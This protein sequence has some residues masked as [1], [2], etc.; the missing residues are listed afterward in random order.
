M[1]VH[2]G[3]TD[4]NTPLFINFPTTSCLLQGKLSASEASILHFKHTPTPLA[5]VEQLAS[6]GSGHVQ[7]QQTCAK[8]RGPSTKESLNCRV[9]PITASEVLPDFLKYI[10]HQVKGQ[11]GR[12]QS[13]HVFTSACTHPQASPSLRADD[14]H[15]GATDG[16]LGSTLG[17]RLR[18]KT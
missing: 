9:S 3:A 1:T 11:G 2:K 7:S 10:Q 5:G 16:R 14:A 17:T 8:S 13:F 18:E 12:A 15:T 6:P 4:V